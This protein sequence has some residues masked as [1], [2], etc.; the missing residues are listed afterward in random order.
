MYGKQLHR[1]T[2]SKYLNKAHYKPKPVDLSPAECL[3]P[4]LRIFDF[5]AKTLVFL[6]EGPPN[7]VNMF[8]W[9]V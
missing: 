9:I 4:S 2:D 3:Q 5:P 8:L 1:K 7:L 6:D